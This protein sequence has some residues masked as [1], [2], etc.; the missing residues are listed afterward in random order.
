M[1][2]VVV[3][4][5]VFAI[6]LLFIRETNHHTSTPDNP[7][8]PSSAGTGCCNPKTRQI[9]PTGYPIWVR[10]Q[11]AQMLS[12]AHRDHSGWEQARREW[13]NHLKESI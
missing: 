5:A 10:W 7:A 3:W 6:A 13:N 8:V 2:W 1:I 12:Y 11:R 9:C 4:M